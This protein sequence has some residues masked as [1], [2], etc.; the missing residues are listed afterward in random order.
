MVTGLLL[1]LIIGV[2][3]QAVLDSTVPHLPVLSRERGELPAKDDWCF[4]EHT[5]L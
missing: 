5:Q 1:M 3:V 4:T 2:H